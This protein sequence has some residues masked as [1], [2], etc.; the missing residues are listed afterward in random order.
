VTPSGLLQAAQRIIGDGITVH[1]LRRTTATG[2]QRL[3]V[4]LEVTEAVLNHVSGS[5]AGVVGVYQRHDW[6]AEKRG[7]LD[8]WARHLLALAAGELPA[9]TSRPWRGPPEMPRSKRWRETTF[10][11]RPIELDPRARREIAQYLMSPRGCRRQP[12]PARSS[13]P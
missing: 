9:T 7:A 10:K 12:N 1:D 11:A 13:S 4:R 8:A 3:G 5:R 2:L 6:A